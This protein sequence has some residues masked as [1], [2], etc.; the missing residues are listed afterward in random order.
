MK[1]IM[2][3]AIRNEKGNALTLVLVLLVVGGLILTPLLGLMSTGLVSGQLYERKMDEY[4]AADA[5]VEDALWELTQLQPN[6]DK[7]PGTLEQGPLTYTLNS[8][9]NDKDIEITVCMVSGTKG[10][11]IYNIT[12]TAT[13][14]DGSTTTIESY[15]QTM[16]LFWS[17]VITSTDEVRLESD[18]EVYGNVMGNVTVYKGTV[19]GGN[20]SGPCDSDAWPFGED[21]RAVYWPQ[22]SNATLPNTKCCGG[23]CILD[24]SDNS[25]SGIYELGPGFAEADKQDFTIRSTGDNITVTLT[26]TV[27]IK[28]DDARLDIGGGGQPFYLDLNYQTIYVEGRNHDLSKPQDP[29]LYIPPGKVTIIGSGVIIAEGNIDFQPNMEAG[30]ENEFVFVMSVFGGINFQPKGT[31]YGSVAARDV[32]VGSNG[33]LTYTEPPRDPDTGEWLLN[34]PVYGVPTAVKILTWEIS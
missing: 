21:F 18:S 8:A 17:N 28:G 22:A 1:T 14:A 20:I 23:S 16:P 33:I 4:Y 32:E 26:D 15:V 2:K 6:A 13:S 27:Y 5:G 3:E 29:A 12:S 34:F 7:V 9:V 24:V 19:T 11:G 31:L 10:G 25:T 30:S